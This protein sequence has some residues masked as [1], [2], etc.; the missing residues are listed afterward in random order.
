MSEKQSGAKRGKKEKDGDKSRKRGR[1]R[2]RLGGKEYWEV[3]VSQM[4]T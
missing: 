3:E 2:K 4:T 1:E